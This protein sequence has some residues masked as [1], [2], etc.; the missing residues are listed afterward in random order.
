VPGGWSIPR[1]SFLAFPLKGFRLHFEIG[2]M[3]TD[4]LMELVLPGMIEARRV[5]ADRRPLS[6]EAAAR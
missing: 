2:L 4:R 6:R 3:A 5:A 1:G